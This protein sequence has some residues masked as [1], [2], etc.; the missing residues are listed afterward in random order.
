MYIYIL[1]F[2]WWQSIKKAVK[3]WFVENK[4][5]LKNVWPVSLCYD[6]LQNLDNPIVGTLWGVFWALLHD[7]WTPGGT[8]HFNNS[9]K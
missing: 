9:L 1:T 8:F 5:R 3:Q 7:K 4:N 2:Y 6:W